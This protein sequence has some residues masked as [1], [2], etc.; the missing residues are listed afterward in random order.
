M[1]VVAFAP[2]RAARAPRPPLLRPLLWPLV[3]WFCRPLIVRGDVPGG[4]VVYAA[5]HASHADTPV[6]LRALARHGVDAAPAAAEDYWFASRAR[7]WVARRVI[8]AFPFPRHGSDGITRAEQQLARGRSV[9]LFPEGTRSRDGSIA[10]FRCGVGMLAARGATVVPVAI[11][12]TRDVLPK[13]AHLP[14]RAPVVVSFGAPMRLEA[15]PPEAAAASEAAVMVERRV[16]ALHASTSLPA[17]RATWYRRVH[18]FARSRAALWTVF[19]WAVA[20]ALWL[21]I[22]PDVPV[23]LLV[24]AAPLRA[25][26]LVVAAIAGTTVGGALAFAAGPALLEHAPLVTDRMVDQA[27]TWL[28]ADGADA[29]A[30]QPWSGIPFKAFALQ[31]PSDVGLGSFLF[32][33]A[34]ARGARFAQVAVVFA[35]SGI[36]ARPILR[37]AYA[38]IAVGALALFAVGLARVVGAWS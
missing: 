24:L 30:R 31:L 29:V 35:V 16:R 2:S 37:R 9:L 13:G 6:I 17:S 32:E 10:G 4:P 26:M 7:A 15:A 25:P 22:V 28:A 11:R 34:V 21:P 8:G 36:C 33:T 38:P 1:D 20:E 3:A 12:G 19:A 27:A 14:R 5:N 18:V 23:A